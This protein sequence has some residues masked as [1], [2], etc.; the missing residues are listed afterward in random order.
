[1]A[2]YGPYL[3]RSVI[4]HLL[5][6][7][8]G[9]SET[10][11]ILE[12]GIPDRLGL[13]SVLRRQMGPLLPTIESMGQMAVDLSEQ[14]ILWHKMTGL[15]KRNSTQTWKANDPVLRVSRAV[16]PYILIVFALWLLSFPHVPNMTWEYW[17]VPNSFDR[18]PRLIGGKDK[19][20]RIIG[21]MLMAFYLP[22][23]PSSST[24]IS[25]STNRIL[26]SP[27]NRDLQ[28]LFTNC[29]SQ[30]LGRI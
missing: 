26:S 2:T 17:I 1:M 29:F 25:S 19:G 10:Y 9:Y 30:Y 22:L 15:G 14:K 3:S 11:S 18:I 27:R 28:P 6:N 13:I 24:S 5:R 12:N 21:A 20:I 7:C 16:I 23:S 8:F 4:S